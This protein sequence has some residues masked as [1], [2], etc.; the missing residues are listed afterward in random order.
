M[1]WFQ[2]LY[3]HD[4]P[5][6]VG[7]A[8][9]E[10]YTGGAYTTGD[11]DF[12]G[13]V[14]PAVAAKLAEGGFERAGRHWVHEEAQVFLELPSP[15]LDPGETAARLRR[16]DLSVVVLAPE[17]LIANRL[18]SWKFWQSEEDGV[19]ALLV[20]RAT[21]VDPDRLRQLARDADVE[22]RLHALLTFVESLG[23]EELSPKLLERYLET[24]NAG[25]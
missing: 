2:G 1:A 7:G 19:N 11:L 3:E 25:D 9:V 15:S 6:L 20:L 12:A 22:D 16:G 8:A 17:E 18:A 23:E 24:P 21:E 4:P 10:L 13:Q 5:V 14:P